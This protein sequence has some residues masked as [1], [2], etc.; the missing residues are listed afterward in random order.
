M[1]ETP[2]TVTSSL[3]E[4]STEQ[5]GNRVA[6]M[7]YPFNSRFLERFFEDDLNGF[8]SSNTVLGSFICMQVP[9]SLTRS[10]RRSCVAVCQD[11]CLP[12][13]PASQQLFHTLGQKD[14]KGVG[15]QGVMSFLLPMEGVE[16]GI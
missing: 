7:T 2:I 13:R 14:R 16:G 3:I 15:I 8:P 12:W 4:I 11:S 5:L 9:D 1:K 6:M 10:H